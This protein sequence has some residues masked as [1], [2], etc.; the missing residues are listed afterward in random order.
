MHKDQISGIN[1]TQHLDYVNNI[2]NTSSNNLTH[3]KNRFETPINQAQM[4]YPQQQVLSQPNVYQYQYSQQPLQHNGQFNNMSY[5]NVIHQRGY[6]LPASQH[7]QLSFNLHSNVQHSLPNVMNVGPYNYPG[8]TPA[9]NP[10]SNINLNPNTNLDFMPPPTA[11]PSF[12]YA[13]GLRVYSPRQ[14]SAIETSPSV[15]QYPSQNHL[16]F[17]N[18]NA[19]P[20]NMEQL[21]NRNIQQQQLQPEIKPLSPIGSIKNQLS[22][23]SLINPNNPSLLL[24]A[25]YQMPNHEIYPKSSSAWLPKDDALLRFLK[26]Y[27][28]LGWREIAMYFPTRTLNACQ[29]RWRRLIAG[30]ISNKKNKNKD[31]DKDKDKDKESQKGNQEE[32]NKDNIKVEDI[33]ETEQPNVRS[34]RNMEDDGE[35]T[36]GIKAKGDNFKKI[37]IEK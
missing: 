26:E 37:K 9:P 17:P 32:D 21:H 13:T 1:N 28:K 2:N 19:Q 20:M 24:G 18:L 23:Q 35:K 29:F 11:I 4:F 8:L 7:H 5:P 15:Y 22:V 33:T 25:P 6:S 16:Q 14:Q 34:K 12:Q 30:V 10:N 3:N 31:K 27:R 36:D